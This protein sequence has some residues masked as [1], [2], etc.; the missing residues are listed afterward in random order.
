MN[1]DKNIKKVYNLAKERAI[2]LF[3][4]KLISIY[5]IG[6]LSHGGFSYVASDIDVAF[7]LDGDITENDWEKFS[8]INTHV[9]KSGLKFSDRL[10]IFWS[11]L[12]VLS[13]EITSGA[14]PAPTKVQGIFPPFDILDLCQNGRLIY[15]REIRNAVNVP[16]VNLLFI[17]G[18]EFLLSYVNTTER[19][20]YLKREELFLKLDPVK[21][22]KTILF[23]TRLLFTLL[24]GKIGSND[25]AVSYCIK[26]GDLDKHIEA[27]IKEAM[28]IRNGKKC[29]ES[30][31]RMHHKFLKDYYI[32]L[33]DVHKDKMVELGNEK[34]VA[35]LE[36]WKK[37]LQ[38]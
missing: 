18:V 15:G 8:S 3:D 10:S 6:S 31:L 4:K 28:F 21:I 14:F 22:S 38:R 29:D 16:N 25:V 1:T 2:Y 13:N 32:R 23:P 35:M 36:G 26:K 5:L 17:S 7:I 34:Y 30:V 19:N 27:I 11:T 37:E 9:K 24:T 33:I 20:E 12:N